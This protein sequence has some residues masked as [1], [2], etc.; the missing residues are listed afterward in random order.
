MNYIENEIPSDN[1]SVNSVKSLKITNSNKLLT[2][3]G[4][5][6]V[7]DVCLTQN[8]KHDKKFL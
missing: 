7:S 5:A 6:K 2:D 1:E 3:K 4:K 8:F